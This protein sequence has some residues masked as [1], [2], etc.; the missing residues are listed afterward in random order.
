MTPPLASG[1]AAPLSRPSQLIPAEIIRVVDGDTVDIRAHVWLDHQVTARVRLRGID[2]PERDGRCPDESR[3]AA[4]AAEALA[5]VLEERPLFLSDLG[6]DKFGGRVL[7]RIVLA[8][9]RD[10]GEV[11][12]ASGHARPYTGGRRDRRCA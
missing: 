8:S 3:R 9:G 2:A 5:R 7:G 4:E 6:R 12:I 10:A 11:M 1:P